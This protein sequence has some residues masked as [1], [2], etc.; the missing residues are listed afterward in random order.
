MNTI[1]VGVYAEGSR[2]SCRLFGSHESMSAIKI[3][4]DTVGGLTIKHLVKALGSAAEP[5]S[6]N[7]VKDQ[8]PRSLLPKPSS[9]AGPMVEALLESA[10][11]ASQVWKYGKPDK[12]LYWHSA[13]KVWVQRCLLEK[14]TGGV[15][16][17]SGVI[18][19]VVKLATVEGLIP[20]SHVEAALKELI[21]EGR[22]LVHPAYIGGRAKLLSV[23]PADPADYLTRVMEQ[24]SQKLHV[25][26][27]DLTAIA[28]KL[29]LEDSPPEGA[30]PAAPMPHSEG[31]GHVGTR[32]VENSSPPSISSEEARH[33]ILD[34]MLDVNP[35]AES[36]D[37][38]SLRELRE[39][40]DNSLD[41]VSFDQAILELAAQEKIALHRDDF[42]STK[43]DAERE[44]LVRDEQ[45][46]F[47]NVVSLRTHS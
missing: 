11:Q 26:P 18:G 6:V 20:K 35:A 39:R 44:V 9:Q 22:I 28:A 30:R 1:I 17:R 42:A 41:K 5:K 34:A 16:T 19:P 37:I 47:Y 24:L 12:A 36:G 45:G 10:V 13:P 4:T 14:L 43:T 3:H 46:K 8:L 33:R 29:T 2:R 15:K 31:M 7:W 38:V 21:D 40:L 27:S 25:S 32:E 23:R